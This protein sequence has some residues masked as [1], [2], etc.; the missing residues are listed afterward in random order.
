MTSL[1]SLAEDFLAQKRIAVAGVSRTAGT[2]TGNVI[3]RRFRDRGYEVYAV[4]PNADSV[5]DDPCYPNLKALPVK[6]DG[7]VIATA[8]DA[9][10][11]LVQECAEVGIPRVWIHHNR[12]FGTGSSSESAVAF[13][14]END[15]MVIP[16]GCP[17]MFGETADGFHK[18]MRWFLDVTGG[19]QK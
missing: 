18:C 11:Q 12:M 4:N 16:G 9:T 10:E 7:L 17:L 14:Q 15:I 8:P 2:A 5:E 3:Y 19:L 13:C 1:K 6:V